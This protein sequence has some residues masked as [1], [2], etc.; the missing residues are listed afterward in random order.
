MPATC[1]RSAHDTRLPLNLLLRL[2]LG[3]AEPLQDLGEP[4]Q[5]VVAHD[6]HRRSGHVG[7]RVS[8][9]IGPGA[10]C[11]R[12]DDRR[13]SKAPATGA[14]AAKTTDAPKPIS[15]SQRAV[16]N[17]KAISMASTFKDRRDRPKIRS[18]CQMVYRARFPSPKS[19]VVR[20]CP[21]GSISETATKNNGFCDTPANSLVQRSSPLADKESR[22]KAA[23]SNCSGAKAHRSIRL[24]RAASSSHPRS[25]SLASPRSSALT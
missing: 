5:A 8:G 17:L 23:L 15:T 12:G 9:N 18:K 2:T 22:P 13:I 25:R 7:T 16:A 20:P 10:L 19:L 11:R 1:K 21:R 6:V 4:P 14:S 24:N 3:R